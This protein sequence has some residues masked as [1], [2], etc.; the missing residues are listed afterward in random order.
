L[1]E[2]LGINQELARRLQ[3]QYDKRGEIVRVERGLQLLRPFRSQEEQQQRQQEVFEG[4]R[5]EHERFQ[6]RNQ[7]NGL[8]ENFCTI[9]FRQNINDPN[10]ADIFN[11]QGGRITRLN[12]Q[13]L[14]ILNHVQMS[15][16]RVVL[17]RVRNAYILALIKF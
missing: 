6:S 12:S 4:E 13:K 5:F 11:P 8:D 17:R 10:R 14:P 9:K 2:A 7:S 16:T 1:A 3:S 15:A